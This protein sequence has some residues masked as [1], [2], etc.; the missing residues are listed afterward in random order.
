MLFL[1]HRIQRRI[2]GRTSYNKNVLG[3]ISRITIGK[4][5]TI[6]VAIFGLVLKK[7][8]ERLTIK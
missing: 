3:S 2:L 7:N 6:F 4:E 5:K 1:E 8:V